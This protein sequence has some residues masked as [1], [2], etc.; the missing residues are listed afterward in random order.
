MLLITRSF[1]Q[2]RGKAEAEEEE[3]TAVAVDITTAC[4]ILAGKA[5]NVMHHAGITDIFGSQRATLTHRKPRQ[6][7]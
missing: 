5:Y 1:Q 2:A 4:R 3:E 7:S 6:I